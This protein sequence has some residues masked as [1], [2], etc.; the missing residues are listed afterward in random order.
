MLPNPD[1]VMKKTGKT[2]ADYRE[3]LYDPHTAACTRSRKAG[4]TSLE[5]MLEHD[6]TDDKAAIVQERLKKLR[7]YNLIENILDAPLYGMQPCEVLWEV[8]DGMLLPKE[9]TAKPADWFVFGSDGA[10]RLRTR[11]NALDGIELPPYRFLVARHNHSY[12]NPYGESILS[13]IWWAQFFK[14]NVQRFWNT[15]TEKFGTPFVSVTHPYGNDAAKVDALV[16]SVV[17][18]VQDA[19]IALPQ[20]AEATIQSVTTTANADMYKEFVSFCNAEI[21]KAILG[22]T[23]ST[24]LGGGG[25]SYAATKAHLDV[26]ADIVTAD[27]RLVEETINELIQWIYTLNFGEN[28]IAPRFVMYEESDVDKRLAE[29]DKILFDAGIRFTKTYIAKSYGLEDTDF[30][31][32]EA[33]PSAPIAPAKAPAPLVVTEELPEEEPDADFAATTVNADVVQ[34]AIESV[35]AKTPSAEYRQQADDILAPV[36]KLMKRA[37]SFDEVEKGLIRTFGDMDTKRFSARLATQLAVTG[38][39]GT[40]TIE[41]EAGAD[42]A[43]QMPLDFADDVPPITPARIALAFEMVP[44]KALEFLFGKTSAIYASFK[45]VSADVFRLVFTVAGVMQMD[46]LVAIRRLVERAIAEGQSFEEFQKAMSADG[47]INAVLP[48][49][50][51]ETIYRTNLQS[52]FMAARYR[53]QVRLGERKPYWK[54]V[55]VADGSTTAGCRDLDGKVFR[56]DDG[57]WSNNYP[58]R[59]FRCRSRVVAMNDRELA[60]YGGEVESGDDYK[61]VQPDKAFATTPDTPFEP[62]KADYPPDVWK[63]YNKR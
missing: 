11:E 52:A 32:A 42:F 15:F 28:A 13:S 51:F 44:E 50:R 7:I 62:K 48:R 12:F 56:F 16:D 43:A 8:S 22:Q 54:F 47:L 24:E 17:E 38:G 40:K 58:P 4:V 23:L 5:W 61:N 53:E 41:D 10:L 1:V 49:S 27:K 31:L 20:G 55:A 36:A 45:D 39:L 2:I 57:F 35:V 59:H 19:V 34:E 26:R 25:G 21:S 60:R 3:L 63:E 18:M 33:V 37:A 9:I 46:A 29:R 6:D 14:K 30:E